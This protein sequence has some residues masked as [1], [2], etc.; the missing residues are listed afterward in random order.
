[1]TEHRHIN[2]VTAAQAVVYANRVW[3]PVPAEWIAAFISAYETEMMAQSIGKAFLPPLPN[4]KVFTD[5]K[6][7]T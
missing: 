1:M 3:G 7:T 6:E 2:M 5:A 4:K